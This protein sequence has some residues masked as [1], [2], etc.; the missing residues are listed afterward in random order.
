MTD[1]ERWM[2]EQLD[3]ETVTV[4]T[5]DGNLRIL[6]RHLFPQQMS[7]GDVLQIEVDSEKNSSRI[8]ISEDREERK[9]RLARSRKQ[10][11]RKSDWDSPGDIAL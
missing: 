10:V 2:V 6:P 7:E 9:K 3:E 4:E 1:T 5:Q 11:V 8:I